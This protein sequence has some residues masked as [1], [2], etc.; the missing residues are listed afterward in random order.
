[1]SMREAASRGS[2]R[3]ASGRVILATV[4]GLMLAAPGTVRSQSPPGPDRVGQRVVQK[5]RDFSLRDDKQAIVGDG[6]RIQVYRVERVDGA[7]LWLKAEGTAEGSGGWAAA[8]QVIPLDKAVAFFTDRIRTNPEDGFSCLM[9]AA[10]RTGAIERSG[11]PFDRPLF[12]RDPFADLE[13][14]VRPGPPRAAI[15]PELVDIW[16]DSMDGDKNLADF[17]AAAVLDP[18]DASAFYG[19]VQRHS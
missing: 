2:V 12:E 17:T 5:A 18:K 3:R 16:P 19:L 13:E 10:I 7:R 4:V 9:R 1:M 8:D 15:D 6:K 14:P 11:D